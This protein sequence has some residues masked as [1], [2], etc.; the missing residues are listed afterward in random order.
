MTLAYIISLSPNSWDPRL[1]NMSQQPQRQ[2]GP[3]DSHSIT[4]RNSSPPRAERKGAQDP[5]CQTEQP[6]PDLV[7]QSLPPC[8]RGRFLAC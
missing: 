3:R 7:P 8:G 2:P 6:Q 1:Q 5:V 4:S